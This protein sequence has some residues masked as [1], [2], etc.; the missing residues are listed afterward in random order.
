MI[1]SMKKMTY[2]FKFKIIYDSNRGCN[3]P[4][5]NWTKIKEKNFNFR[6]EFEKKDC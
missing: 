4:L 2:L 1:L 5:R 6:H 3:G